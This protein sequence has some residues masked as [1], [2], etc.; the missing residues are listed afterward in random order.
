MR[1]FND[2]IGQGTELCSVI[3]ARVLESA[4]ASL[5]YVNACSPRLT[6][7]RVHLT[8]VLS[9]TARS[10]LA[11]RHQVAFARTFRTRV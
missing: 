9:R 11:R 1:S 7:Q 4:R 6:R 8:E 3:S 5:L 10:V 2:M